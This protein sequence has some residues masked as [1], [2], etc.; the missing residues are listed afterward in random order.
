MTKWILAAG[1]AALAI[2]SPAL[3][4]RG[5]QGSGKGGQQAAKAERGGGAARASRGGSAR[6]AKADRGGS[7]RAVRAD[8]GGGNRAARVDRGGS[9]RVT[10]ADRG[11]ENRIARADRGGVNRVARADRGGNREAR[12]IQRF[13]GGGSNK[14]Q[15]SAIRMNGSDNRVRISGRDDD[16]GIAR[17]NGRDFDRFASSRDFDGRRVVRIDD[18][19]RLRAVRINDARFDRRF[20]GLGLFDGCPPGLAKKNNGCLPPGRARKAWGDNVWGLG[21]VLPAT[22]YGSRFVPTYYRDY[23]RS[24]LGNFLYD[25]DDYYYRYGNGNVYRVDRDYNIVSGLI[26]LFGGGYSIG[27]PY[28]LGYGVYNVPN[29]YRN[30]Y[31]DDDDYYYRYGDGGIYQVDRSTGVIAAVVAL[32]A[33][34]LSVGQPLPLGYDAYN[35]PYAY[36]ARYY[37]TPDTWYRYNDGYVYG[38]N[39]HTRI[40]QTVIVV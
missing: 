21:A 1:A 12:S 8:R 6:A 7:S 26:P 24:F 39:P 4:E 13:A 2:T 5:G 25:N 38:V 28:P 23:D 35:V 15:E 32:L 22:Y 18:D 20:A 29:Q 34:G 31:Y 16:R 17:V 33:G 36:R 11:G 3:A 40:V 27:Q 14:R 19:R 10:R 30:Y 37:D 9:N